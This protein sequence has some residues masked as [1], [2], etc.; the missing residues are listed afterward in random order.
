MVEACGGAP[1]S[2]EAIY[3]LQRTEQAYPST[4]L[5]AG[6]EACISSGHSQLSPFQLESLLLKLK[7]QRSIYN[8][9][10]CSGDGL[11]VFKSVPERCYWVETFT[12]KGCLEFSS[13]PNKVLSASI[14]LSLLWCKWMVS[15][16]ELCCFPNCC[17]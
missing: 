3:M 14:L 5:L 13:S 2:K 4:S 10:T 1:S 8:C 7:G 6:F 12:L 17:Q 9:T 15:Q 11:V 16:D